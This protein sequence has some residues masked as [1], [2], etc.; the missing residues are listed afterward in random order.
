MRKRIA[1]GANDPATASSSGSEAAEEDLFAAEQRLGGDQP[2][3]EPAWSDD[4]EAHPGSVS[5]SEDSQQESDD[6]EATGSE[7]DTDAGS[8][9]SSELEGSAS[10]DDELDTA[11]VDYAAATREHADQAERDTLAAV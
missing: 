7:A 4:D 3:A 9:A 5:G 6:S 2:A 11:I 8:E 10:D 1:F